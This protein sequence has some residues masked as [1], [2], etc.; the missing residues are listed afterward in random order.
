M[1]R[2][3][4]LLTAGV[5]WALMMAAL[6]KRELLPYLELQAPPTYRSFL[7]DLESS[8]VIRRDIYFGMID[9][10]GN[11]ETV[12][13]L[14][15]DGSFRMRSR[16]DIDAS[17]IPQ[18]K[19]MGLPRMSM[20]SETLIDDEYR[21]I[22]FDARS[23]VQG[24]PIRI[25]GRRD[26]SAL[27]IKYN[28]LIFRDETRIE[29]FNDEIPLSANEMLPYHGGGGLRVGK[30]WTFKVLKPTP[31]AKQKVSLADAFAEVLSRD[32]IYWNQQA[33]EVFT[34]EIKWE[35]D[36]NHE[37]TADYLLYIDDQ[38]RVLEQVMKFQKQSLRIVFVDKRDIT[39]EEARDW[40]FGD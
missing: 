26:G 19:S 40:K 23:T 12:V 2:T 37:H 14:R 28:M 20:F 10:V 27:V 29:D 24:F 8:N 11:I 25:S 17:R 3:I 22:S 15:D 36:P 6:V 39:T 38:G 18:G 7:K 16:A 4:L 34:V 21:L 9:K 13:E 30:R 5:F 32:L 35:Y 33:T 31:F 1:S